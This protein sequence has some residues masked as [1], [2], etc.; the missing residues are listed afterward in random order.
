MQQATP[1][2]PTQSPQS[3]LS[4]CDICSDSLSVIETDNIKL[5]CNHTFHLQCIMTWFSQ[6]HGKICPYCRTVSEL[7]PWRKEW[8]KKYFNSDIF[9]IPNHLMKE[10]VT[11]NSNNGYCK[12]V[13][14]NGNQCKH[15]GKVYGYCMTHM[16][17]MFK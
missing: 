15:Y 1:S 10:S 4:I 9:Y 14:L 8:N 3:I 5:S 2:I 16:N 11:N 17:Q 13:I 7:I 6:Y 12:G